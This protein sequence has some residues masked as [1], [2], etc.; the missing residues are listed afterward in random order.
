[1]LENPGMRRACPPPHTQNKTIQLGLIICALKP[2]IRVRFG[3]DAKDD[4]M[5]Y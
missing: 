5:M 4:E 2:K 3:L 1:M